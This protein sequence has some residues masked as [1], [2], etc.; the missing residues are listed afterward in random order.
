MQAALRRRDGTG[1]YVDPARRDELYRMLQEKGRFA[2][3]TAEIRRADGTTLWTSMTCGAVYD[4]TGGVLGFAGTIEDITETRRRRDEERLRVRAAMECASDAILIVDADGAT[5]FANAAFE[6]CFGYGREGLAEA[7]GLPAVLVDMANSAALAQAFRNGEPWQEEAD[8]VAGDGRV[9]PLLIRVSTIRDDQGAGFGSVVICT[10]L[11]DRRQA[12]ARIQ[13]MAH[14]DWL[15]GLPNRV[16]FRERLNA[17]IAQAAHEG[18]GFA[19]LCL[20]LDRFKAVN[21]TLGHPAGDRLLQL[22]ALRLQAVVREGDTVARVG[23]DEFT[24]I[25]LGIS[26]P[27]Q[28]M[29]LAERLIQALAEPFDLDGREAQIG[30]SVGVALAPLHGTD[31]DRLLGFADVALYEAKSQGKRQACVFTPDMDRM[32][33]KRTELERDLRR[34][35]AEK[36]LHLHFQ[37]QYLLATETLV[38]AEALLRWT[39]PQRGVVTPNEFIPVAEDSG[40]IVDIGHLV[41]ETACREAV[42]WPQA[43][44]V[45]VNVSPV[46]FHSGDLIGTV[47]QILGETGLPASR[48]ELE[49][50]E[51]VL[52]HDTEATRATLLGL[53]S[54]G[55]RIT[56]D[57]FGTGYS[58][59]SYLRRM[60]F[61]KIKIDRSFVA[62][63][64]QDPAAGALVRSIIGLAK[65]LGLQTNAEGV[66]TKLQARLLRDEGC[67]EVQGYYYSHP[68]SAAAFA[69]LQDPRL[70]ART[71]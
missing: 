47:R 27:D 7:G 43:L 50:T 28:A 55:V 53:K 5:L 38:G 30:A 34:A 39:D 33:R 58:S 62:A 54:L 23:G 69:D 17:A 45:A 40:L 46:Q 22:A 1:F 51:G 20:D 25:Q 15:T 31:P 9:L 57:D 44:S 61:D 12:E 26:Q 59:L 16:F 14:Y 56:L 60:P 35:V 8:V 13:H 18:R 42:T 6:R 19:V 2:G 66:E 65:G 64:G 11:T 68:I 67:Q 10:D 49:I 36:R 70:F 52:L 48:L 24:L 32:L 41:L 21:D 4:E 63:L 37:P 3:E 29:Q 71:A